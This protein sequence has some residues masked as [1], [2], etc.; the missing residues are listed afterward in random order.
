MLYPMRR[1]L[2]TALLLTNLTEA[3]AQEAPEPT[4]GKIHVS[5]AGGLLSQTG[6]IDLYDN[7]STGIGFGVGL[8]F[9]R[10]LFV[11]VHTVAS[12]SDA[13]RSYVQNNQQYQARFNFSEYGLWLQYSVMTKRPV[14]PFVGLQLGSGTS[15]WEIDSD[16]PVRYESPPAVSD[17]MLV[18]TPTIGAHLNFSRWFRPDLLLGYRVI[19]GLDL[20]ETSSSDLNGFFFGFNMMFGGFRD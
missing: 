4:H 19:H 7:F 3:D 1:F 18:I 6:S 14:Q 10:R 17:R 8:I 5:G 9:N 11:G 12:P 2:L 20:E 13:E 16:L 15:T